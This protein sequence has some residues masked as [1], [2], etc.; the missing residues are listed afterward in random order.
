MSFKRHLFVAGLECGI[1]YTDA[2]SNRHSFM[3]SK[4][5]RKRHGFGVFLWN[6]S[7]R[8]PSVF[9][10]HC[11]SKRCTPCEAHHIY[12]SRASQFRAKIRYRFQIDA[13]APFTRLMKT[14]R[15]VVVQNAPLLASLQVHSYSET[16]STGATQRFF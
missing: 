9:E 12:S 2:V 10:C 16:N 7:N 11:I 5:H 15:Y 1:V 13:V 4:P 14:C 3:T 8:F 6:L